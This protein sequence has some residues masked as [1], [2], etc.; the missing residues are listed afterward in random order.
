M[1]IRVPSAI[2]LY[3]PS[4]FSMTALCLSSFSII[5]LYMWAS[6]WPCK[7]KKAQ[8]SCMVGF[9][10]MKI[11][12]GKQKFPTGCSQVDPGLNLDSTSEWL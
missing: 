10:S 1:H 4:P 12:A 2:K 8:G 6:I 7:K 11:T 9:M 3:V 5:R